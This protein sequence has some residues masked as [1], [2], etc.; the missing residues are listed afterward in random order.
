MHMRN[1]DPSLPLALILHPVRNPHQPSSPSAVKGLHDNHKKV[2][3]L[4]VIM[5]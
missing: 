1:S 2:R 3:L 4:R 5:P